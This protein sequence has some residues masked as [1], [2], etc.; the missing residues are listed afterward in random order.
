MRSGLTFLSKHVKLRVNTQ[1]HVA[2]AD[3]EK[4][5]NMLSRTT[6]GKKKTLEFA[7]I[8][9]FCFPSTFAGTFLTPA[10]S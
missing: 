8:Y 7:S 2:G 5:G 10:L 9:V 6:A 1:K 3:G 4:T